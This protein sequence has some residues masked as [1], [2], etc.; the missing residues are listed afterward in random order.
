MWTYIRIMAYKED[1][2]IFNTVDPNV[3]SARCPLEHHR[4][5]IM[6]QRTLGLSIINVRMCVSKV[7]RACPSPREHFRDCKYYPGGPECWI[8]YI[9]YRWGIE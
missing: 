8:S 2:E 9:R 1:M 3:T 4:R 5:T 6:A 7:G